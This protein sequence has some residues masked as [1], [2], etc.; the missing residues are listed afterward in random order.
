MG[1]LTHVVLRPF[2]GSEGRRF[3]PGERVAADD[4]K[5]RNAL[6]NLR[7]IRPLGPQDAVPVPPAKKAS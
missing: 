2:P 1:T 3:K 7:Y 6:E 4:W 5:N